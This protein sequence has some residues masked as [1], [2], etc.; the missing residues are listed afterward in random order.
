MLNKYSKMFHLG[1]VFFLTLTIVGFF[2]ITQVDPHHDGIIMK[3]AVDVASGQMLFRDTFA[4]YGALTTLVQSF[5]VKVFGENLLVIRLLTVLA[6]GIT[7]ILLWLIY[8]R[9][10]P[11]WL[12]TF[13][14][15]ICLMLGYFLYDH[16]AMYIFP[17]ATVFA[18]SS[19]LASLYFLILFMERQNNAL[20]F[21]AGIFSSLTFWFKIN[22]GVISF[23]ILLLILITLHLIPNEKKVTLR[24]L[25]VFLS[26]YCIV[27]TGFVIWL[28]INESLGDF[29]IQT[30]KFSF[31][32]SGNNLFSSGDPFVLSLLK[33]LFQI[34]SPH[35]YISYI[36]TV[37]PLVASSIAVLSFVKLVTRTDVS[38]SCGI[39]FAISSVSAG[40]WFGYYPINALF[41]MYLS[42]LL[43][44]GLFIYF[45]WK[46]T[47]QISID[48]PLTIAPDYVALGAS[49]PRSPKADAVNTK[50]QFTDVQTINALKET[51]AGVKAKGLCHQRDITDVMPN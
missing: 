44:I 6:Y 12:C 5:A 36:W 48:L 32:F 41:H 16:P 10:L 18:I 35:G 23:P 46:L 27:H 50:T 2:S 21:L 19:V 51:E 30:V 24:S 9:I 26:G 49:V 31:F 40:L 11:Q 1:L 13:Y 7:F 39:T 28:A 22:Y 8:S 25:L 17:S 4:Q 15:I 14:C 3:P 47:D 37:I 33:S 38:L 34:D 20:V 29:I 43:S 45:I 42:S